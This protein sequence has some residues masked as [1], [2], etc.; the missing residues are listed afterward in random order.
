M[1]TATEKAVVYMVY[2]SLFLSLLNF[3]VKGCIGPLGVV[4]STFL[5]YFVPLLCV[6]PIFAWRGQWH[7]LRPQVGFSLHLLRGF[8]AVVSQLSLN[9]YLTRATLVNATMLWATGPIFIPIILHFLYK[10]KTPLVTWISIFICLIGV[11]LMIKPN[12]GIFDPFAVWGLI[13]GISTAFT[14]ILW[15]HNV[16]KGSVSENL[17]YLYVFA[18]GLALIVW[19]IFGDQGKSAVPYNF[20][21]WVAL[22]GI[23]VTSLGNQFFRSKAYQLAPAFLLTPILYVAVVGAGIIDVVFYRNWPDIWGYIGFAFVCAGTLLKWWYLKKYY[24]SNFL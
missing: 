19:M 6:L 16:E 12:D 23:G 2:S 7:E 1:K 21:L 14:Q 17:F 18:S 4:E 20:V 3:S 11:V 24:S 8:F 22:F 5:R 13:A 15:G 9:Y 10:Q